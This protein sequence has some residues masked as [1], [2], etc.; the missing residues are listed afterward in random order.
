MLIG[1]FGGVAANVAVL[2]PNRVAS[3]IAFCCTREMRSKR[4]AGL[5]AN[6]PKTPAAAPVK[7]RD[8]CRMVKPGFM[9]L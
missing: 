7:A 5:A 4:R 2:I 3:E 9:Y 1:V 6:L 8:R